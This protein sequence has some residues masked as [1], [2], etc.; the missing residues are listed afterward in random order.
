MQHAAAQ[1]MEAT[2]LHQKR[3]AAEVRGAAT[4]KRHLLVQLELPFERGKTARPTNKPLPLPQKCESSAVHGRPRPH[5]HH[6]YAG[7]SVLACN[8][9]LRHRSLRR[10]A[11]ENKKLRDLTRLDN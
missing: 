8:L 9:K 4:S 11:R 3:K 7:Q 1:S 10:Q 5:Q 2:S 6:G